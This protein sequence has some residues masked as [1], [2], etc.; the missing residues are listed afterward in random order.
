MNGQILSMKCNVKKRG[1]NS[2]ANNICEMRCRFNIFCLHADNISRAVSPATPLLWV[3][4]AQLTRVWCM[5]FQRSW[6]MTFQR[7]AREIPRFPRDAKFYYGVWTQLNLRTA[8]FWAVTQRVMVIP[9]RRFG[10][11]Y[12]S[13]FHA[14]GFQE[15]KILEPRIW[16]R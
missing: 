5:T 15:S 3:T 11:T 1:G 12:R 6:C 8:L 10:T 14:S 2:F 4:E 16:D 9:Y 7:S 13:H